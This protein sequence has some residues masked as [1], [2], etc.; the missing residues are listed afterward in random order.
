M[1]NCV[2]LVEELT[3][4]ELESVIERY[5]WFSIAL[6]EEFARLSAMKEN[7]VDSKKL[8]SA[9]IRLFSRREMFD[10]STGRLSTYRG[11]S[12]ELEDVRQHRG[13]TANV[14]E[15][16]K[17]AVEDTATDTVEKPDE[18]ANSDINARKTIVIGGD[19]FSREDL[20]KIE[21][22]ENMKL[23]PADPE[24]IFSDVITFDIGASDSFNDEHFFTETLAEIYI[25][26]GLYDRAI[27][28]YSK[29]ILLYPEKNSY[30][31]GLIDNL[32]SKNK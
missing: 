31:A 8:K 4:E 30:F 10:M 32:K 20:E 13:I 27:E 17:N 23:S 16:E 7:K 28:V 22:E 18:T 6:R 14:E 3:F 24:E 21:H 15:S 5:P 29:L 19:Y 1:A 11:K 2:R 26:Q 12:I 25:E 9:A